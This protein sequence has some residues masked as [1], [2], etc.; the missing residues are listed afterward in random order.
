MGQCCSKQD[1][2]KKQNKDIDDRRMFKAAVE[3]MDREFSVGIGYNRKARKN[4]SNV[5]H[6]TNT[7]HQVVPSNEGTRPKDHEVETESESRERSS[8]Q[9]RS[10][11]QEIQQQES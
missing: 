4:Y 2:P 8:T 1:H 9:S 11:I 10:Q 5:T 3:F 6:V 7:I